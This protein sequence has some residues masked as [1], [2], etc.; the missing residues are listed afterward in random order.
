MKLAAAEEAIKMSS[1]VKDE[2]LY[3][4]IMFYYRGNSCLP[5]AN[6]HGRYRYYR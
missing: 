6:G 2:A 5:G 1:L 4:H 3:Y